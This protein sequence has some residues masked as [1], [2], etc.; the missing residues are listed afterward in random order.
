MNLIEEV[1][2]LILNKKGE[3][4]FLDGNSFPNSGTGYI[5][6]VFNNEEIVSFTN[7]GRCGFLFQLIV[8]NNKDNTLVRS[9]FLI[10]ER[11]TDEYG[12]TIYSGCKYFKDLIGA[13]PVIRDKDK[14]LNYLKILLESGDIGCKE[15]KSEGY[16]VN[17]RI[18][19]LNEVFPKES[20][21]YLTC[22]NSK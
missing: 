7:S 3:I 16:D 9:N 13:S 5:Y 8:K 17:I 4:S 19:I 15:E 18:G 1:D 10:H 21:S 2:N 11:Y 14:F 12:P 6:P 22:L 20:L